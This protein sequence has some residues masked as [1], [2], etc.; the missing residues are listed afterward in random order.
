MKLLSS[1]FRILQLPLHLIQE[2]LSARQFLIFS[3]I[4][5]GFTTGLA[6][7]LLK[8]LVYYI[9]LLI[10]YDYHF[11][12]QYYLYLIFPLIG[13]LLTV[14]YVQR[15]RKGKLEKGNATI[16]YAI[17]KNSGL[18][19]KHQMYSQLFTSALTVGFGGSAGLESPIVSTGAAIGS[20]YAKAYHLNILDRSLLLASGVAAGIGAVF[21]APIAGVLFALEVLLKGKDIHAFIPILIAAATGALTSKIILNEDILLSFRLQQRFNYVNIPYYILLGI[22]AGLLSAYYAK[23]FIKIERLY[24]P[25]KHKVWLS[26]LSGGIVL[27]IL[28][29]FF[30]PLFGE[31][32]ESIKI[33]SNQMP[34]K[35][36]ENGIFGSL[37][38][39]DWFILFFIGCIMFLKVIA[40]SITINSGGNGGNFAPSLFVGAYLGYFFAY[41]IRLLKITNLPLNNF[42]IVGMSGILSGI[43]YAPLTAIF[44]IAEI[45]GGYELIIPL[46]IVSVSSYVVAKY[47]NPMSMDEKHLSEKLK[48]NFLKN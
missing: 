12:Y 13:I 18:L 47:F 28:I 41:V 34:A 48:D 33:L 5:V 40:T 27:A 29:F 23:M 21:N 6:A 22:F 32:Y 17:E 26:A 19:P 4:L 37:C 30:P 44:L 38:H 42:T 24:L 9:H 43:F 8:E 1:L 15:I 35:L 14:L 16:L 39:Y 25:Y 10:K 7:V 31:G 46:I 3:S 11:K 20:N 2:R 45:T 36:M